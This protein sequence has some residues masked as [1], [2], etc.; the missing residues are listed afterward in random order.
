MSAYLSVI[1]IL[2][3]VIAVASPEILLLVYLL[4]LLLFNMYY[5][6]LFFLSLFNLMILI[7]IISA[8]ILV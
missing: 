1:N 3:N 7:N 8:F 4:L 2:A 6:Q 5:C